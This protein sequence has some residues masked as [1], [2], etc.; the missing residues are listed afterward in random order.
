MWQRGDE[1]L[2]Y[3]LAFI[4]PLLPAPSRINNNH[5]L[6]YS[7][8]CAAMRQFSDQDGQH[9]QTWDK[10]NVSTSLNRCLHI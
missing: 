10:E 8:F 5:A 4:F 3:R 1:A 2:T 7:C 9:H 6:T